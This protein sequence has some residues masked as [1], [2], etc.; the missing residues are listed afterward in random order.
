MQV[1]QLHNSWFANR[2]CSVLLSLLAVA[3]PVIYVPV[4]GLDRIT[5]TC[6]I[7]FNDNHFASGI[8]VTHG[9]NKYILITDYVVTSDNA[10][11][12]L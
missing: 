9:E 7:I 12:E 2:I 8:I 6:A 1:A 5:G 11:I 10:C 4:Y 3:F